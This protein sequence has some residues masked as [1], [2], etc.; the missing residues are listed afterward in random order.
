MFKQISV[1]TRT[2]MT[3]GPV[4]ADPRVLKALSTPI[5]GQYD[6]EFFKL[7]TEVSTL[8]KTPFETK[9][10]QAFVVDGTSRSGLEA[11]MLG[12]VQP[13]DR[14][15]VPA[16]GRFGY[17]FVEL[18]QRAGAEV[19]LI[20]KEWGQT[21]KAEEVISAIKEFNPKIVAMVHGETSTGQIQ[22]LKEIGLYCQANDHLFL[23]DAVATFCGTPVKVDEW[24]IDIA[25][26]GTQK[27]LSVP[28][29]MA[30]ITYNDKVE[31]LLT[32]R[33]QMELGLSEEF[34]NDDFIKSNYLDL[35][36]IQRYWGPEHIN[37]HTEMTSMIYG[38]H[39]GLRIVSEEGLND[40][41]A[42]HLINEK[43]LIAGIKAMGLT[44]FGNPSSKMVTVTC[45]EIPQDVDGES[46]RSTLLN[47]FGVEIAS[48]FGSLKGKIWRIGNMGYSSRKENVLHT[49]GALES[50]I[51][52]H[53]GTIIKGEA[54]LAAMK[55]YA[56]EQ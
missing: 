35:S 21:F 4:E 13:G 32:S 6:P 53:G 42:R 47:E 48:S 19:K 40:R 9:N 1:P 11:A 16:Y 46:V 31:K 5:I 18:A 39:E 8:L 38:I 24:G 56:T 54:T 7:M 36:Q 43:A 51:S 20:E 34:R 3:P 26:G 37:H 55:V 17:L 27:C 50:S 22:D 44:L 28:S 15:L 23:V 29:G 30:P 33:Y 25:V 10:Q 49:L 12:L 2:I 41:Y 45:V 52:Y 14:V